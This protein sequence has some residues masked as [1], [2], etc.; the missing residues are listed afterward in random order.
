M[1]KALQP[2]WLGAHEARRR[3]WSAWDCRPRARC[4]L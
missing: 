2:L 3:W 4:D 1:T